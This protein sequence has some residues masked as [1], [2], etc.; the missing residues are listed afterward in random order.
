MLQGLGEHGVDDVELAGHQAEAVAE[1]GGEL[2]PQR[3]T[4]GDRHVDHVVVAVVE[5]QIRREGH[6]QE[7][8]GEHL[9]HLDVEQEVDRALDLRIGARPV[10]VQAIALA[11]HRQLELDRTMAEPV[12]I[13]EV[14]ELEPLTVGQMRADQLDQPAP[15]AVEDRVARLEI[16]VLAEPIAQLQHPRRTGRGARG[17]RLD[18]GLDLLG[19]AGVVAE[20]RQQLLVERAAGRRAS[21]AASAC[22]RNRCC[23][24]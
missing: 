17:D 20:Q 14:L 21:A 1:R 3:A 16:G 4:V 24:P 11:P 23:A 9:E 22:P 7:D 5:D 2:R 12:V 19:H 10:E 18:V 13:G 8:P 6:D 15:G